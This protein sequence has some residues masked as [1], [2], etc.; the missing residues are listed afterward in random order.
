VPG[1]TAADCPALAPGE[2][3]QRL[4]CT[5]L[6]ADPSLVTV[7]ADVRAYEPARALFSDGAVKSRW[8]HLPAGQRID[9]SNMDEWT[10]PLGTKFWKQFVIDG[11]KI[12]TRYLD[13]VGPDKWIM[14]TYKWNDSETDAVRL[15]G[16][17]LLTIGTTHVGDSRYE[18][19]SAQQCETCHAGRIDR[20]LGFEAVNLGLAGAGGLTLEK[21][22]SEGALTTPPP[23]TTLAI[24]DDGSG[25]A[26]Q[27]LGWLHVNCGVTCHNT[28]P[29]AACGFRGMN[30]RLGVAELGPGASVHA[31]AAYQTT[32]NV[33]SSLPAGGTYSRIAPGNPDASAI[34]TLA[35]R[36]DMSN[37]GAQMPP[38]I[39]HVVDGAGVATLRSWI[40]QMQQM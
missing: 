9:T 24:P 40:Q 27:A 19:P 34:P 20:V 35:G 1:V 32:V 15:D 38:G 4:I 31:L 2:A 39:S 28:S 21:L 6:Y 22:A 26:P 30:L 5:G 37:P 13:K 29:G 10:F 7:A 33:A 8:V 16:G 11:K 25:L 36:R 3:P 12:E 23:A 17:E 14:A 18:I